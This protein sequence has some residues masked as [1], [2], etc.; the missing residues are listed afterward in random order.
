MHILLLQTILPLSNFSHCIPDLF[1]SYTVIQKTL[2]SEKWF[3]LPGG[4]TMQ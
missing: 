2:E 1:W 3:D 4:G